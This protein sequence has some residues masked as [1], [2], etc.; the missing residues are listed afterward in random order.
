[1]DPAKT[2][3][4]LTIDQ[5]DS[6]TMQLDQALALADV[7]QLAL[8]GGDPEPGSLENCTA[9]LYERLFGVKKIWA[10][11]SQAQA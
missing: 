7:L 6:L 3:I 11:A 1:M 9:L 10:E 8:E 4:A 5:Y 2:A